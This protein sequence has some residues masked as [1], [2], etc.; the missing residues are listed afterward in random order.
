ME[1]DPI[2]EEINRYRLK[3]AAKFKYNVRAYMNDLR[4]RERTGGHPIATQPNK[5]TAKT[6]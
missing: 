2:I 4:K 1:K 3:C 5:A 6:T